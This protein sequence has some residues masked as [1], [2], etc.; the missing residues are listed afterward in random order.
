MK[1]SDMRLGAVFGH[2]SKVMKH[3]TRHSDRHN[4]NY[5]LKVW[6]NDFMDIVQLSWTWHEQYSF[7]SLNLTKNLRK[8]TC[9][10][11]KATF[12]S[13]HQNPV[14]HL[15]RL[16]FL[17]NKLTGV[18]FRK[19]LYLRGSTGFWIRLCCHR[20]FNVDFIFFSE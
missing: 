17:W 13:W 3:R 7:L 4:K 16:R 2:F 19:K 8:I 10:W 18:Y 1:C 5:H 12:S 9:L 6:Q 14:E 15:S 20:C 11:Q